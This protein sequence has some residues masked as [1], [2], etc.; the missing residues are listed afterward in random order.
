M[1][2]EMIDAVIADGVVDADEVQ[3]LRDDIFDDGV[4]DKEEVEAV[5]EINDA[6]SG[7]DNDPGWGVL[8]ADVVC[9]FALEDEE[10]P[11]VVDKEEGDFL[12]DL[13][14]GDGEVD[15]VEK[16]ALAALKE[17]AESIEPSK[18]TEIL[19]DL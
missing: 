18:L 3:A 16:G 10:T 9:G 6:V 2:R 13:I 12:A 19:A 17:K 14:M 15:D 1:K 5:F 11:G 7:N 4:V 8:V